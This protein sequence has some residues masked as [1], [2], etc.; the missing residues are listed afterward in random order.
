[1]LGINYYLIGGTL[2]GA[3]RHGGFIPWDV[4]IDIAMPRRDYEIFRKYCTEN[5]DDSFCYKDYTTE[6]QGFKPCFFTYIT[7]TQLSPPA[8][9]FHPL[10]A[11]LGVITRDSPSYPP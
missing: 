10:F 4:D 6:K 11:S 9:R 3:V 8:A 7:T 2:L 5:T 1:M